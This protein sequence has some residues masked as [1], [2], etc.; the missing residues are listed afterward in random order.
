MRH[1]LLAILIAVASISCMETEANQ[2][3]QQVDSLSLVIENMEQ[4]FAEIDSLGLMAHILAV[5]KIDSLKGVIA[6]NDEQVNI[7]L[8]HIDSSMIANKDS[9]CARMDRNFNVLQGL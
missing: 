5:R 1:I 8:H 6:F 3:Q 2:L 7:M 9:V 4:A